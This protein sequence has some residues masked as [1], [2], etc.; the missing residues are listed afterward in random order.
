[1]TLHADVAQMRRARD[2]TVATAQNGPRHWLSEESGYLLLWPTPTQLTAPLRMPGSAGADAGAAQFRYSPATRT[3]AYTITASLALPDGMTTINL[4]IG[5]PGV[6]G[7][8]LR[9]LYSGPITQGVGS[10]ITGQVELAEA[11]ELWLASGEL[12]VELSAADN[13]VVAHGHVRAAPP[14][15]QVPVYA[16]PRAAAAM[17]AATPQV[18]FGDQ[19]AAPASVALTGQSL[20]GTA[21]PTDVLALGSVFELQLRSPNS[22]PPGLEPQED[23]RY[24]HADLSYVGVTSNGATARAQ[25][26]QEPTLFF[27]LAVHAPWSTP[28]EVELSVMIDTSGDGAADYRLF[29]GNMAGYLGQS[30]FNDVFISVLEQLRSGARRVEGP[31]NGVAP[32]VYDSAPF[33]SQVMVLP[34]KLA[35]LTGVDL[36]GG[37]DYWVETHSYDLD[38]REENVVDRTPVLHF[39]PQQPALCLL[40]GQADAPRFPDLPGANIPVQ[41][42]VTGYAGEFTPELMLVH[43]HN[44]PASQVEMVGVHYRWPRTLHLPLVAR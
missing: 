32:D 2:A 7:A 31:L 18:D 21:Y 27:A 6:G 29:N 20:T 39:T 23:D 25:A 37:F 30:A 26:G 43:H 36:A 4:D 16:A 22:R 38:G 12:Y 44:P 3:L 28:N 9:L 13:T 10:P 33:F 42:N 35:D 40:Q 17:R 15:L 24:D 41:L 14:V 34:V 19:P 11:D 5:Q 8:V 1:M